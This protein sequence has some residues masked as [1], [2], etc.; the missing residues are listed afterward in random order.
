MKLA[1]SCLVGGMLSGACLLSSVAAGGERSGTT[2]WLGSGEVEGTVGMAR[3]SSDSNEEIG[4]FVEDT[5]GSGAYA[6]CYARNAA[7]T[8]ASCGTTDPTF[9]STVGHLNTTS[10]VLFEYNAGGQCTYLVVQ[11]G[12][13]GIY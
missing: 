7:G 12:S 13:D 8:Y 2:V 3:Y 10:T 5:P 1:R 4:C 6:G 11:N 9:A